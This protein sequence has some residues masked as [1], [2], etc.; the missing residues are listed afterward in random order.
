MQA[1][2]CPVSDEEDDEDLRWNPSTEEGRELL[3]AAREAP[4]M[5]PEEEDR[6]VRRAQAAVAAMQVSAQPE[7]VKGTGTSEGSPRPPPS[8]A[9][10]DGPKSSKMRRD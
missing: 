3:R 9:G 7:A 5:T 8:R 6:A 10:S 4:P 2:R 1:T